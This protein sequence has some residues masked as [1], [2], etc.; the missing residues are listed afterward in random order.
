MS[1]FVLKHNHK[2]SSS[3]QREK[4]K[5][6]NKGLHKRE[7]MSQINKAFV[8]S[9][10]RRNRKKEADLGRKEAPCFSNVTLIPDEQTYSVCLKS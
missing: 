1:L 5:Q 6:S 8:L 2:G 4:N 7:C 3:D 9:R 10:L